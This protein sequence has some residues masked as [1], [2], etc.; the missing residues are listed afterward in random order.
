MLKK[1]PTI[2]PLLD[3]GAISDILTTDSEQVRVE[4][5][6][7]LTEHLSAETQAHIKDILQGYTKPLLTVTANAQQR[8]KYLLRTP[9]LDKSERITSALNGLAFYVANIE[10]LFGE[11]NYNPSALSRVF[12]EEFESIL[13][14]ISDALII[15][16]GSDGRMRD[17]SEIVYK[18]SNWDILTA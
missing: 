7:K 12:R 3:E 16:D 4:A 8:V 1:Q 17:L 15:I 11:K 6:T 18:T 5:L 2:S 14:L 13:P 10:L 9:N